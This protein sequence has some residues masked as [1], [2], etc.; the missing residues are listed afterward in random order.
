MKGK[1]I[2]ILIFIFTIALLS[3]FFIFFYKKEFKNSKKGDNITNQDIVNYVLNI[4]YFEA[5]IEVEVQSNKNVNKYIM[6]QKYKNSDAIVQ[7]ILEPSNIS[8]IKITKNENQLKIENSKLNLSTIFE[9]YKYMSDNC[10]DLNS[11][12]EDYKLNQDSKWFEEE[13]MVVMI[14][15][16]EGKNKKLFVDKN[17]FKPVK[18]V[19]QDINQNAEIYILYNEINIK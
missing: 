6:K 17:T 16:N 8:G 18:L 2:F 15:A 19:I 5:K 1:N 11:F 3:V 12:I 9:D 10:L 14:T 4:G 7:E 13:N